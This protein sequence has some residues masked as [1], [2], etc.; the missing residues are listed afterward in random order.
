MKHLILVINGLDHVKPERVKIQE[1]GDKKIY[2]SINY[3]FKEVSNNY[4][5]YNTSTNKSNLKL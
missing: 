2:F 5:L 4:I 1:I 3:I